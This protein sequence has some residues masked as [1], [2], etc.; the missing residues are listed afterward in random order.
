MALH[1]YGLYSYG[2]NSY[3]LYSS[4]LYSYDGH[5]HR[6]REVLDIVRDRHVDHI[7]HIAIADGMPI[8]RVW[9]RRY[10]K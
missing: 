2:Q 1:G 7:G 4:G 3:G 5:Q 9:P 6:P 10:S 8:A